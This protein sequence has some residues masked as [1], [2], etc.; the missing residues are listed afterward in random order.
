LCKKEGI[1]TCIDT[2][3]VYTFLADEILDK[4]DLLLL[5]IKAIESESYRALTG[6]DI[7]RAEEF[8]AKVRKKKTPTIIRQVVIPGINDTD[9]YM[10]KL[11]A[12]IKIQVPHCHKVELLPYHTLGEHKYEK[13]GLVYPLRG[14]KPMD[15]QR[16]QELLDKHVGS[17][18]Y[19]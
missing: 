8:M 7:K 17:Y 19:D 2:S 5:D 16:T 1:H 18:D 12:Y 14:I 9:E 3:G 10:E 11:N 4:V 6:G 13:L 15:K